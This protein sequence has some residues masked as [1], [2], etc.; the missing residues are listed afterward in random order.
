MPVCLKKIVTF[1]SKITLEIYV[2]QYVIIDKIRS[3]KLVFPLNWI[4][5][6]SCILFA[7]FALY[8]VC[9]LIYKAV[10]KVLAKKR[11]E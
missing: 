11:F 6:T 5:L 10:D 1:L 9:M 8:Y 7:A 4:I 3:V 2:V